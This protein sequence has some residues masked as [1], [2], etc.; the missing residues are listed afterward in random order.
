M[1]V[2]KACKTLRENY[3]EVAV[4]GHKAGDESFE[5]SGK[6]GDMDFW[7]NVALHALAQ[8][9]K[10]TSYS[11]EEVLMNFIVN[12]S[13]F[14][15]ISLSILIQALELADAELKKRLEELKRTEGLQ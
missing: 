3:C 7:F 13:L 15:N 5:C 11:N 12:L 4:Y 6:S 10:L 2:E 8:V 14:E 9:K 1:N